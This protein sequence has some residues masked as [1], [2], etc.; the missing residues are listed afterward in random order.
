MW[1]LFVRFNSEPHSP[2]LSTLCRNEKVG[3][4]KSLKCSEWMKQCDKRNF[5]IHK[6]KFQCWKEN[7]FLFFYQEFQPLASVQ[8]QS[9]VKF[10]SSEFKLRTWARNPP[11][12]S[13]NLSESNEEKRRCSGDDALERIHSRKEE[14]KIIYSARKKVEWEKVYEKGN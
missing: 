5:P 6:F 11:S 4:N 1:E 13:E 12:I 2:P 14:K 10:H 3:L 8:K 9:Y 7:N